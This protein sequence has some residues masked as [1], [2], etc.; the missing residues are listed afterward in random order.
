[1]T[2]EYEIFYEFV[3][4]KSYFCAVWTP[5]KGSSPQKKTL[6]I[7][8]VEDTLFPKE[9]LSLTMSS[10]RRCSWWQGLNLVIGSETQILLTNPQLQKLLLGTQFARSRITSEYLTQ[11]TYHEGSGKVMSV[12][13]QLWEGQHFVT[14]GIDTLDL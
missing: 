3:K 12:Q 8:F 1:M 11:N 7:I 14:N 10:I 5:I 6:K 9:Y 13:L 2:E 4:N